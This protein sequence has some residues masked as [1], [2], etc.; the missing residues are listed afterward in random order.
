MTR[1]LEKRIQSGDGNCFS[2]YTAYLKHISFWKFW[3]NGKHF[4]RDETVSNVWKSKYTKENPLVI[5]DVV[6]EKVKNFS[7]LKQSRNFGQ[8]AKIQEKIGKNSAFMVSD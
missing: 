2:K 7:V 8:V 4:R 5:F 1:L 6:R 3:K